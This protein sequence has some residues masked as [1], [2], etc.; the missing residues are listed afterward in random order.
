MPQPSLSPLATSSRAALSC[1]SF[2][3]SAGSFFT[4]LSTRS[5]F[6]SLLPAS[7][8]VR[9]F[10]ATGNGTTLDTA[11]IQRAIAAGTYRCFTLH[12][13]SDTEALAAEGMLEPYSELPELI[14]PR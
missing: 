5:A 2:F 11:A 10:G 4:W 8:N 1:R 3:A 14:R 9:S 7:Y 12:L 6:A 13:R